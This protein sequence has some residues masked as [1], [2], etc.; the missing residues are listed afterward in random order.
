MFTFDGLRRGETNSNVIALL[1]FCLIAV[2][3]TAIAVTIRA[4]DGR[5]LFHST[6][7][8]E[9][10][11]EGDDRAIFEDLISWLEGRSL[12]LEIEPR[13]VHLLSQFH[14]MAN[15]LITARLS[16]TEISVTLYSTP[17]EMQGDA[18]E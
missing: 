12:T 5:N 9:R 8:L 15:I 17:P 4:E 1:Y 10:A 7:A 11:T 6:H 13:L 18:F 3:R 16:D 14:F 2:D